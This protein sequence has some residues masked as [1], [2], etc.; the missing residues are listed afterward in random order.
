V[1]LY[2]LGGIGGLR[3]DLLDGFVELLQAEGLQNVRRF[4]PFAGAA[5]GANALL[6]LQ[7]AIMPRSDLSSRL[8]ARKVLRE[9]QDE[10]APSHSRLGFIAISAG[11]IVA[12]NGARLL[13]RE[14][15][16]LA[17]ILTVGG[18]VLRR[19]PDNVDRWVRVIGTRDWAL[20]C[21]LIDADATCVIP[22]ATHN[23]Y[24]RGSREQV[25]RII[26]REFL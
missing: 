13:Q 16:C 25:S 6:A 14:G 17:T 2:V 3:D 20:P 15:V 4:R 9:L 18:I 19:K 24:L 21:N 12:F 10:T 7:S 5:K 8:L 26:R 22:G 11:A 23:G 1:R